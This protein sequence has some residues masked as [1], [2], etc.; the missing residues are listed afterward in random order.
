MKRA[1][2]SVGWVR[3]RALPE[4]SVNVF[5]MKG[6]YGIDKTSPF[7]EFERKEPNVLKFNRFVSFYGSY[8]IRHGKC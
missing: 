4:N 6:R 7:I 3:V 8:P 1:A 5:F 2:T